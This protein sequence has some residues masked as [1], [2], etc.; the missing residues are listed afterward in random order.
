WD[1]QTRVDVSVRYD[2]EGI[3]G[4][5]VSVFLNLNNLTDETDVRYTG[6]SWNPNQ[7]ESYGKRY[8]AGFRYS[9]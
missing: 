8:L 4:H 1:A 9:L 5:K 6:K 3:I 2:L 7:V